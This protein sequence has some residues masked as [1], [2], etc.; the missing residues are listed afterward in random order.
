MV[1]PSESIAVGDWLQVKSENRSVPALNDGVSS[2][3]AVA[4]APESVRRLDERWR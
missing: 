3:A 1:F 2:G 4:G